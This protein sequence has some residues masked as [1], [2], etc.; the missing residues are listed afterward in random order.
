MSINDEQ[1]NPTA[2]DVIPSDVT[3][4]RH[5]TNFSARTSSPFSLANRA[6][7]AK[8]ILVEAFS[9]SH[10]ESASSI[11]PVSRQWHQMAL[12]GPKS[13]FLNATCATC[14]HFGKRSGFFSIIVKN[15]TRGILVSLDSR[16]ES[17]KVEAEAGSP[18]VMIRILLS[19]L[20]PF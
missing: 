5:L 11:R 19:K 13:P 7:G 8:K 14:W 17:R 2:V 20:T 3:D 6:T 10:K 12:V 1:A 15:P 18:D 16:T 4:V 9:E